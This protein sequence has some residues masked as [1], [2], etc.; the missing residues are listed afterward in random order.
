MKKVAILILVALAVTFLLTSV[1]LADSRS[2]FKTIKKAVKQN[3]AYKAGK[4]AKWFKILITDNQTKKEKLKINLPISLI[5][6]VIKCTEDKHLKVHRD[7]CDIDLKEL[8]QELKKLGPMTAIELYEEGETVK[9][10]LE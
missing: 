8:F 10:W 9:I 6:Y 4:E 3:P 5:E 1:L 2:D 7:E